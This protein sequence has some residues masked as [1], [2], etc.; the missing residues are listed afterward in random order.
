MVRYYRKFF[1]D[2]YPLALLWLVVSGVW[3]RFAALAAVALCRQ[4]LNRVIGR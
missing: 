3:L 2:R 4:G 1:R